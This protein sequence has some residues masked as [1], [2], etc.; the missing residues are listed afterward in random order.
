MQKILSS[1]ATSF[2]TFSTPN[3]ALKGS[4]KGLAVDVER[5]PTV[6]AYGELESTAAT[7]EKV[8]T[9]LSFFFTKETINPLMCIAYICL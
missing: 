1:S 6:A 4:P 8:I 9:F 5:E 2:S 3:G 7:P